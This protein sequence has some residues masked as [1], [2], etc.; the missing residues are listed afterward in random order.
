MNKPFSLENPEVVELCELLEIEEVQEQSNIS[1]RLE[2]I[3]TFY[4][5]SGEGESLPL[6]CRSVLSTIGSKD[7]VH[8]LDVLYSYVLTNK[9]VGKKEEAPANE[10]HE[11]KL[12]LLEKLIDKL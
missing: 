4:Q 10:V 9:V 5:E 11:A 3:W 2:S 6:F 12:R 7:G 8:P 1:K